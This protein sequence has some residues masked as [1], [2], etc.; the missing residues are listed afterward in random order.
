MQAHA[1]N[2][3]YYFPQYKIYQL[4]KRAQAMNIERYAHNRYHNKR[5]NEHVDPFPA[6]LVY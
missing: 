4:V 6:E 1:S 5:K 3:D 2:F